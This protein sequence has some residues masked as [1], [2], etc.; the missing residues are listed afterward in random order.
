MYEAYEGLNTSIKRIDS[1]H[2]IHDHDFIIKQSRDLSKKAIRVAMK[3]PP[4][5]HPL[6]Q[7]HL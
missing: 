6:V 7:I 5:R 2:V 1:L 3:T 4:V